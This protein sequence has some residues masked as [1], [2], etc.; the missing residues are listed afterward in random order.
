[1]SS[2]TLDNLFEKLADADQFSDTNSRDLGAALL[3]QFGGESGFSQ[4]VK[5]LYDEADSGATR[6]RIASAL[7]DLT[8]AN[9]K[10][11]QRNEIAALS[12]EELKTELTLFVRELLVSD[13]AFAKELGVDPRTTAAP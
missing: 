9:S 12:D 7:L 13:P 11:E 8:L 6:A 4:V 1:M 3:R 2:P 10:L 5:D